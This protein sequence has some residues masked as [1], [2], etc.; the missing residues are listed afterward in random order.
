MQPS[1]RSETA[2]PTVQVP[3]V[4]AGNALPPLPPQQPLDA[5]LWAPDEAERQLAAE[6]DKVLMTKPVQRAP[7]AVANPVGG[8]AGPASGDAGAASGD[9]GPASGDDDSGA[10]QDTAF[11]SRRIDQA[12]GHTNDDGFDWHK[13]EDGTAAPEA[14]QP[15]SPASLQWMAKARSD[16]RQRIG[17]NAM[18]WTVTLI[19]GG[20]ILGGAAYVLAGWRPDIA[21]LLAAGQKL[22]S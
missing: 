8:D 5:G 3:V 15:A 22:L 12:R 10:S 7:T 18:G 9:A 1:A 4:K 11:V 16:R 14:G 6:L 13:P 19:T 21:A 17:R 20:I 2:G